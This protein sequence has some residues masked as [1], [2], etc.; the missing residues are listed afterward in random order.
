MACG[1]P[2]VAS[3]VGIL[4]EINKKAYTPVDPQ[5]PSQIAEAVHRVM[6]DRKLR[7]LKVKFGLDEIKK[8]S[9]D[10]CANKTLSVYEEVV[11]A[12]V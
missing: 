10:D 6:T 11:G 9:W 2:V 7:D 12:Y 3:C 5:N 8:F 4:K 1:T